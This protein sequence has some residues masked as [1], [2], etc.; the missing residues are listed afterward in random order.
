MATPIP[1]A[2]RP[3]LDPET[4]KPYYQQL[5]AFVA[6]ERAQGLVF[7]PAGDVFA[8]LELTPLDQVKVVILGQDPYPG[9]GEAHGLSFSVRPGVKVPASLKNIFKEAHTDVGFRIPNNGSLVPWARQ[10]VLLLNTVLTVR[11]HQAG[12]HRGHGWERF[13]DVVIG[14]VNQRASHVVFVLWGKDAQAKE[15][16]IDQGRHRVVKGAHPSPL[17][18]KNFFGTR[19]FSTTN[20]HL[21]GFGVPEIDWQLPDIG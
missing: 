16:M 19:P 4:T 15:P 9:E 10:G 18:A 3:L 7:P 20:Q 1:A 17:S 5:Q 21:R 11:A 14:A 6:A 12:S 8:A 2:W 13:T